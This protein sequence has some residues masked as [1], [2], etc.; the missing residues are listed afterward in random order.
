MIGR[1]EL[2]TSLSRKT[3]PFPCCILKWRLYAYLLSSPPSITR[4]LGAASSCDSITRFFRHYWSLA[5]LPFTLLLE[6][7]ELVG[8]QKWVRAKRKRAMFHFHTCSRPVTKC[9]IYIPFENIS[10]GVFT[11]VGVK[12]FRR[13]P[14][15]IFYITC[16]HVCMYM[17]RRKCVAVLTFVHVGSFIELVN[18][19]YLIFNDI[20]MWYAWQF[21]EQRYLR[22]IVYARFKF[23]LTPNIEL[24]KKLTKIFIWSACMD[25]FIKLFKI[26]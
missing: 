16:A 24:C 17:I 18:I 23:L 22:D 6:T 4:P 9:P 19:S 21:I 15:D 20:R 26:E 10:L 5:G 3:L 14:P 13:L 2:E 11:S 1:N 8:G 7:A 25:S 12:T